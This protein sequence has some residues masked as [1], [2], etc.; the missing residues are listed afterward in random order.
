MTWKEFLRTHW[1]VLAATDF[2][3]VEV[4]T[5]LGLVRYHVLFMI[6]LATREVQIAGIIP[7]PHERWM[8]QVARNLSDGLAGVMLGCRYL[9]H[10][11]STLFSK[12]FRLIL[13]G[14]GIEPVRLPAKFPNLNAY[15]ERFVRTIKECCLEQMIPDWRGVIASG[16]R[17]ISDSLSSREESSRAR[18]QVDP[19]RIQSAS[20]G[21]RNQMPQ[22]TGWVTPVLLP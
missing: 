8:K 22:T 6:R 20:Q 12:S 17:A 7:E 21:R 4:W 19:T 9:L 16:H 10:D 11:R 18:E 13:R 14:A 3:T 2:F 15:S 1:E 5:A